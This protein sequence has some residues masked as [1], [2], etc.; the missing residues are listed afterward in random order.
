MPTTIAELLVEIGVSVEGAKKAEDQIDGLKTSG[1]AAGQSLEKDLGGG[2]EAAGVQ[3]VALGNLVAQ[4]VTALAGLALQAVKTGAAFAIDLVTGFASAGDEIAKT[5]RQIGVG[6]EGLQRLRFAAGRSGVGVEQLQAGLKRLQVGLVEARE[7][8]TGPTSEGLELLGVSLSDLPVDDTEAALGVLADAFSTLDN[9]TERTAIASR[10]FGEEAGPALKTLLDE[11]SSGIEALGDRAEEL[12]GVLGEDALG[13]AEQ[14]TDAFTDLQTLFDGVKN[15]IGSALAPTITVLV[16]KITDFVAENDDLIQQDIPKL[17][18]AL[19]DLLP[20]VLKFTSQL[21]DGVA[22]LVTEFERFNEE[23]DAGIG[24][25]S[26]LRDVFT[27]LTAPIRT[28]IDLISKAAKGLSDLADQVDVISKA[29]DRA[30]DALG[31]GPRDVPETNRRVSA[32]EVAAEAGSERAQQLLAQENERLLQAQ[33]QAES[34]AERAFFEAQQAKNKAG[35]ERERQRLAREGKSR[36]GRR[37][38]RGGG[39]AAATAEQVVSDVTFEDVLRG[40]IGGRGNEIAQSIRGLASRTPPKHPRP[41][42]EDA[43]HGSDK[44]N[45]RDRLLQFSGDAKHHGRVGPRRDRPPGCAGHPTR[46]P[47]ANRQGRHDPR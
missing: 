44:A 28:L 45:G 39:R 36:K 1:Q 47:D 34:D 27:A 10:I 9:E 37:G 14:L 7:R 12:G 30:R 15:Q 42:I 19:A 31:L 4:G 8:G 29:R 46:V 32:T 13:S 35:V 41:G 26:E 11:G 23:A 18:E 24:Y 20:P 43:T 2:A 40:V 21:V 16:D 38:G 3:T 6:A 5:S 22:F 17:F 25:A 33:L